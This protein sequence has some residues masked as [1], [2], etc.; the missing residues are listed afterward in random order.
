ML[1][2]SEMTHHDMIMSWRVL[3]WQAD[4]RTLTLHVLPI[5]RPLAAGD[6]PTGRWLSN[7][8]VLEDGSI[9][10]PLWAYNPQGSALPLVHTLDIL[11]SRGKLFLVATYLWPLTCD[12]LFVTSCL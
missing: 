4:A 6:L 12:H 1:I 2:I 3:T 7:I 8:T 5:R 10:F 9:S 11:P